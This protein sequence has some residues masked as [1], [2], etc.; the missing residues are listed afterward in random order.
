MVQRSSDTDKFLEYI[1]SIDPCLQFAIDDTRGVQFLL[2]LDSLVMPEP[3]R[4]LPTAVYRK[5]TP[6]DKY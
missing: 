5:L 4:S 6:T 1:N 2:F 3:E